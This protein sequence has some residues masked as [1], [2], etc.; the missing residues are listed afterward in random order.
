MCLA[1]PMQ[2]IEI[3]GEG[4]GKV[5]SGGVKTD[6]NIMMIPDAR[7]GDY[8]IIHAGFGIEVLDKEEAEIR[9][10]LFKE[11]AAATAQ[12]QEA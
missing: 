8:L 3:T 11:L 1:I 9:L 5:N 2:L 7:I 6:V 10:D 12:E 4:L